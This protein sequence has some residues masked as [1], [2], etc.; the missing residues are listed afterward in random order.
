MVKGYVTYNPRSMLGR[1]VAFRMQ[2][3][4]RLYGYTL[5]LP[6]RRGYKK[7][8][9]ATMRKRIADSDI[10][11]AIGVGRLSQVLKQELSY[12]LQQGKPVVFISDTSKQ[13]SVSLSNVYCI[14]VRLN[15][16]QAV[17]SAAMGFIKQHF[18]GKDKA[19][20]QAFVL[21]AIILL[22]WAQW[23]KQK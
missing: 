5:Y 4:A 22:L 9:S 18:S 6:S 2:T 20:M 19:I 14:V 10:V 21:S 17:L 3:L 15:S 7:G 1:Q 16:W 13:L 8:L 12:A 11:I 23:S